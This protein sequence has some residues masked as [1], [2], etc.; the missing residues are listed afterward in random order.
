[1]NGL[2]ALA[3]GHAR[4]ARTL[5]MQL[6]MWFT[7]LLLALV[8]AAPLPVFLQHRT[9]LSLWA[10]DLVKEFDA[11]WLMEAG[12][13][14]HAQPAA[15]F[16]FSLFFAA[17]LAMLAQTFF[18]GGAIRLFTDEESRYSNKDFFRDCAFHFW[19]FFRLL[20]FAGLCYAA[21]LALNAALGRMANKLWGEGMEARPL[22]YNARFRMVAVALLLVYVNAAMDVAKVRIVSENR[23][24]AVGA[25]WWGLRFAARRYF[26]LLGLYAA[27]ALLAVALFAVYR[28]GE[29]WLPRTVS[30][31]FLLLVVAQIVS[32]AR[33]RLRL[34]V[35]AGVA[36]FYDAFRPRFRPPEEFAMVGAHVAPA[37]PDLRTEAQ[38]EPPPTDEPA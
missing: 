14:F 38:A 24:S 10:D 36:A 26:H 16:G 19:R 11:Q 28:A 27:A 32:L 9:A 6:L 1:M 29:E 25:G 3:S 33:I 37:P 17:L 30:G 35:W 4:T 8:V 18:A 12:R 34:V 13:Y 21:V 20:L 7:F 31:A 15:G 5:R 2:K 23:R 22:V